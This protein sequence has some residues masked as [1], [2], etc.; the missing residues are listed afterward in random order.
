[1]TDS[2]DTR[3]AWRHAQQAFEIAQRLSESRETARALFGE[4]YAERVQV[5]REAI[6]A[7]QEKIAGSVVA[8]VSECLS[9]LERAG[10]ADAGSALMLCAAACEELDQSSANDT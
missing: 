9:E 6:R 1:V 8:A 4:R 5:W 2:G 10:K 7:A 3:E